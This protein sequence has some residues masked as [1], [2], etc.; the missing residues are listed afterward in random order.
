[1]KGKMVNRAAM[2]LLSAK[3]LMMNSSLLKN[4]DPLTHRN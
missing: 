4:M 3:Q 2:H 1:M